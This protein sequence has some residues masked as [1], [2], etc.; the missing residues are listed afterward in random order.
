MNLPPSLLQAVLDQPEDDGAR[1]GCAGW[2]EEHGEADR[3]ELIRVQIALAQ[4]GQGDPRVF[5]LRRREHELLTAHHEEW[6]QEVP[7]WARSCTAFRRGFVGYLQC[8][9]GDFLRR[10]ASL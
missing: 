4:L 1:L 10:G 8:T 6:G 2:L 7:A 3:A 5:D 9:V